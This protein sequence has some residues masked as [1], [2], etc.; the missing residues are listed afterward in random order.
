MIFYIRNFWKVEICQ[1]L[2]SWYVKRDRF[3]EYLFN[4]TIIVIKNLSVRHIKLWNLPHL[5]DNRSIFEC[6]L[7]AINTL[8]PL[9]NSFA[10]PYVMECQWDQSEFKLSLRNLFDFIAK[11]AYSFTMSLLYVLCICKFPALCCFIDLLHET[12]KLLDLQ[13]INI[14]QI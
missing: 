9:I 14:K 6:F 13:H 7:L 3:H 1:N 8:H 12:G 10:F 2:C 11:K 4:T 5:F